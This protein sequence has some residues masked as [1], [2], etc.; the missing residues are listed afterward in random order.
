M[1][2]TIP[3]VTS[4]DAKRPISR[5]TKIFP[6]LTS[7]AP[8]KEKRFSKVWPSV[9]GLTLNRL[10]RLESSRCISLRDGFSASD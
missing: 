4:I 3:P 10:A 2:I 6:Q 1:S 9:L 5:P 7:H 8:Q